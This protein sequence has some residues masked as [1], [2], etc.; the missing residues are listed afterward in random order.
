VNTDVNRLMA[1]PEIL[2]RMKLFGY[3]PA[4]ISPEQM[5]EL[6]RTDTKKNA[7]TVRRSGATAG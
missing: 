1:D 7:E 2:E 3:E 4:P 6:I 5:A